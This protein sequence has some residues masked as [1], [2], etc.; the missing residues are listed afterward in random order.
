MVAHSSWYLQLLDWLD[1]LG[2][3]GIHITPL[4]WGVLAAVLALGLGLAIARKQ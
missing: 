2:G 3:I 4:G 1:F